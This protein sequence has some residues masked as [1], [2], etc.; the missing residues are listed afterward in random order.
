MPNLFKF[1]SGR[2]HLQSLIY[3]DCVGNLA[4]AIHERSSRI[5]DLDVEHGDQSTTVRT[6]RPHKN[7]GVYTERKPELVLCPVPCMLEA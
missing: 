6:R 5:Y 7:F 4:S 3:F 1:S 2:E